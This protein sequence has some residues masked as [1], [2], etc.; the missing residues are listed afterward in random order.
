VSR[1]AEPPADVLLFY[2]LIACHIFIPCIS[3]SIVHAYTS[4]TRTGT[5]PSRVPLINVILKVYIFTVNLYRA[6]ALWDYT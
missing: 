3:M 6:Y 4:E 5:K 1:L 2:V